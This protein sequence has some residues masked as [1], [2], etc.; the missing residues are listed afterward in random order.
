MTDL[1]D[2]GH[3]WGQDI[4]ISP[5][6]DLAVVSLADRSK[7]RVLRR[8]LTNGGEYIDHQDYGAGA[9]QQVGQIANVS[10]ITS[11]VAGQMKREATVSQV[12]SPVVSVTPVAKGVAVS[13]SYLSAPDQTPAA[14]SFTVN[15]NA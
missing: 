4:R 8:L 11:L 1:C 14:L 7:E 6:G 12:V 2:I 5:T 15:Q 10:A 3:L 13:V 9:G